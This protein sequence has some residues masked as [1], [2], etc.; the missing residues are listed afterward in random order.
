VLALW[1]P[2]EEETMTPITTMDLEIL[3]R[4]DDRASAQFPHPHPHA[5]FVFIPSPSSFHSILRM[6]RYESLPSSTPRSV[7]LVVFCS[8]SQRMVCVCTCAD[9]PM[10]H[11]HGGGIILASIPFVRSTAPVCWVIV[12]FLQW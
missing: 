1:S 12:E 7:S 9:Q 10:N 3:D 6:R 8:S 11:N 2:T 4:T 5:H